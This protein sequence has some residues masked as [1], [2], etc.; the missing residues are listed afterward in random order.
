MNHD[1]AARAAGF[2]IYDIPFVGKVPRSKAC[3]FLADAVSFVAGYSGDNGSIAKGAVAAAASHIVATTARDNG[4][5]VG[6]QF[7]AG[8]VGGGIVNAILK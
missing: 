4:R 7:V 5:A 1:E 8:L 3:I 6:I 2:E